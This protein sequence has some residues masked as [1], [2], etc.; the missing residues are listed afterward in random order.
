MRIA[1][2]GSSGGHL[3]H[4]LAL[5]P[6]WQ[7][8]ER[9]WVTFQKVDAESQLSG[10]VVFWCHH[11]TNRHLPNLIRNTWLA[12]RILLRERPQVVVSS[13]AAVAVPFFYLGKLLGARTVYIEVYDR[14]SSPTLTGRMVRPVT[15]RFFVQWP[16]QLK[17]YKDA[18]LIGEIL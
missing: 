11:P 2:V 3:S 18:E 16:E 8:H 1:L 7:E 5:K 4:L 15:D 13:G 6:W 12:L 10:E 14:I 17:F 9:F